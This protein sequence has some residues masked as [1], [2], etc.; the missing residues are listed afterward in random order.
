MNIRC[1]NLRCEVALFYHVNWVSS[2]LNC[3]PERLEAGF[4]LIQIYNEP[5]VFPTRYFLR[6]TNPHFS[7][8]ANWQL[9]VMEHTV[10]G[11]MGVQGLL[12]ERGKTSESQSCLSIESGR[13]THK[14]K[15]QR[16]LVSSVKETEIRAVSRGA[17]WEIA[18]AVMV[19]GKQG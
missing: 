2:A 13:N 15:I 9:Q 14:C 16:D 19:G 4:P 7:K 12:K 5:P 10:C 8:C 18:N 11:W 3:C 6:L 17:F 1:H